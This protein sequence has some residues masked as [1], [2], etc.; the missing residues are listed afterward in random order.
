MT[1]E[2]PYVTGRPTDYRPEYCQQLVE[3]M[4]QGYSF[5]TF[6][7]KAKVSLKSLYNWT[8]RYPEFLQAKKDA[9]AACKLFWEDLGVSAAQGKI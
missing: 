4:S 1:D 7:P 2:R 9:K 6:A 3:H 5:D 8:E